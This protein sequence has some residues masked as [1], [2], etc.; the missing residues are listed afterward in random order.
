MRYFIIAGE[1]SGDQYAKQLMQALA[2]VDPLAEF[3]Y[4]APTQI[5]GHGICRGCSQAG[6]APS[7]TV[8][9]KKT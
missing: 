3:K 4:R 9:C 6:F 5:G 8:R 1:V 7:G 2:E